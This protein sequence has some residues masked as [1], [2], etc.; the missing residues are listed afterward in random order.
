MT[1]AYASVEELKAAMQ[2]GGFDA[3]DT[4]DDELLQDALDGAS[5]WLRVQTGRVFGTTTT[6]DRVFTATDA[7]RLDVVDVA[8]IT[9]ITVDTNGDLTYDR[10]LLST[11]YELLPLDVGQP[12]VLGKGATI[13][14]LPTSPRQFSPGHRV[15]VS[16]TWGYGSIPAR[17]RLA[18]IRLA[19]RWFKL[20]RDAPL[21][22]L[23]GPPDLGTFQTI[24][25]EDP[26]LAQLL[27]GYVAAPASSHQ[28]VVA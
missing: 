24:R 15:K 16:A 9:A 12:G 8:T 4:Q 3:S 20:F 7:D 22:V 17:I 21:G 26:M 10:T 13:H 25:T 11:D 1:T 27:D 28:W 6:E 14:I 2:Q 19:Q 18:T 23:Q 5:D